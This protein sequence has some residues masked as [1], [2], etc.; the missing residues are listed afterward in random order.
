MLPLKR[1]MNAENVPSSTAVAPLDKDAYIRVLTKD[2]ADDRTQ[3]AQ[4]SRVNGELE[5]RIRALGN[6]VREARGIL[7][8]QRNLWD[9]ERS[10]WMVERAQLEREVAAARARWPTEPPT[11]EELV[12]Q[13]ISVLSDNVQVLNE[14]AGLYERALQVA[15]SNEHEVLRARLAAAEAAAEAALEKVAARGPPSTGDTAMESEARCGICNE[16]YSEKRDMGQAL[17]L[18]CGH[19]LCEHCYWRIRENS[20][21]ISI[22]CPWCRRKIRADPLR[23]FIN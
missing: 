5:H 20:T 14:R 7:V 9:S 13:P 23:L 11:V 4:L 22:D 8:E 2:R 18:K 16:T 12:A 15:K 6:R 17:G 10:A 3:L 21:N 1:N 19:V